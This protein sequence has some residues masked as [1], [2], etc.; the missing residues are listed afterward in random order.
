MKYNIL[1]LIAMG[2]AVTGAPQLASATVIL[3][4]QESAIFDFDLTGSNPSP[5]YSSVSV[6]FNT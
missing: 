3:A 4:L 6:E 1:S 5:P 2:L